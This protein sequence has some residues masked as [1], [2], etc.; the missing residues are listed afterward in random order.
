MYVLA[1]E[2][3]HASVQENVIEGVHWP[4]NTTGM[5][6]AETLKMRFELFAGYVSCRSREDDRY[7]KMVQ[8]SLI[9]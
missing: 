8:D 9:D 3:V 2:S 6:R 1:H 7:A 5:G 4:E